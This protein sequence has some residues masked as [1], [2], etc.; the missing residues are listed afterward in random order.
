MWYAEN[1]G[2]IVNIG[3]YSRHSSQ[4]QRLGLI[5]SPELHCLP[6]VSTHW[7]TTAEDYQDMSNNEPHAEDGRVAVDIIPSRMTT[8]QHHLDGS[9]KRVNITPHEKQSVPTPAPTVP[10]PSSPLRPERVPLRVEEEYR[11]YQSKS[12]PYNQ[13]TS[14][15]SETEEQFRDNYIAKGERPLNA[16]RI[17]KLAQAHVK[18]C[19]VKQGIWRK[20]WDTKQ[21]YPRPKKKWAHED[22]L[23]RGA[24]AKSA[25][26]LDPKQRETELRDNLKKV[27]VRKRR[28]D[29]SRPFYQFIY[30]VSE[31]C[32]WMG[33]KEN[34]GEFNFDMSTMAYE[35][36][37][38]RWAQRGIWDRRWGALPG[39]QWKHE[40]PAEIVE[41]AF[42]AGTVPDLVGRDGNDI[43]VL[44]KYELPGPPPRLSGGSAPQ[45]SQK[46]SEAT[47]SPA[48][49]SQHPPIE[50]SASRE[51]RERKSEPLTENEATTLPPNAASP[52]ALSKAED[53]TK[54]A[55]E[56]AEEC[57]LDPMDRSGGARPRRKAAVMALQYL[58]GI[59][60]NGSR[61][62]PAPG[63]Q[64]FNGKNNNTASRKRKREPARDQRPSSEET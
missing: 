25:V 2:Y 55:T 51:Q 7:Y 44:P 13:W 41:R 5:K 28:R 27:I 42:A 30:Q 12:R 14:Q 45:P 64:L 16:R 21:G 35:K 34:T 15:V 43:T 26:H 9:K 24:D 38:S 10:V 18:S 36:V 17:R 23:E 54:E 32:E 33:E 57:S 56:Q 61:N 22:P 63:D 59:G 8:D 48:E 53:A 58:K 49:G 11:Y 1:L 62:R 6:Y 37:K 47:T 29:A 50:P 46:S 52:T 20:E 39:M 19:W 3:W 31:E 4:E 40:E 60:N